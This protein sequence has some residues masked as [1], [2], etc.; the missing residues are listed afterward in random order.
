LRHEVPPQ[1]KIETRAGSHVP[2][3]EEL[4]KFKE[5]ALCRKGVYSCDEDDIIVHNW[6]AFCEVSENNLFSISFSFLIK[7]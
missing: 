4:Q 1:H 3:K 2:T 7:Y 6:K 5:I